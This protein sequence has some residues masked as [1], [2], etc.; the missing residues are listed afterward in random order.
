MQSMLY[1]SQLFKHISSL[2]S[3]ATGRSDF[4]TALTE[5][6]TYSVR[7]LPIH[8][9]HD[10]VQDLLTLEFD[11]LQVY[12]H[13]ELRIG[14]TP[15]CKNICLHLQCSCYRLVWE[16]R[17]LWSLLHAVFLVQFRYVQYLYMNQV[18]CTKITSMCL[19]VVT[20]FYREKYCNFILVR[21]GT[22]KY[23]FPAGQ[24]NCPSSPHP[25]DLGSQ[26]W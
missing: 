2:Q 7:K 11:F 18:L 1:L 6:V 17:N 16:R 5:T 10:I 25:S 9:L 13:S 14:I 21:F 15:S 3:Q 4:H 20:N 23:F 24:W 12:S 26:P 22:V 19:L 8:I